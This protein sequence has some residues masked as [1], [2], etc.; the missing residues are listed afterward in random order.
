MSDERKKSVLNLLKPSTSSRN[1]DYLSKNDVNDVEERR[2]TFIPSHHI[3]IETQSNLHNYITSFVSNYFNSKDISSS[4]SRSVL[5]VSNPNNISSDASLNSVVGVNFVSKDNNYNVFIPVDKQSTDLTNTFHTEKDCNVED[6]SI[7]L[8]LLKTIS[9]KKADNDKKYFKHKKSSSAQ[10]KDPF[11]AESIDQTDLIT[12]PEQTITLPIADN[13]PIVPEKKTA[14]IPHQNSSLIP[15]NDSDKPTEQ[16]DSN[17]LF[18]KNV[19]IFS[20]AG[21]NLKSLQN[22]HLANILMEKKSP[23]K[24]ILYENIFIK[25]DH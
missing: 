5:F 4:N 12:S 24:V 10:N 7:A 19:T 9:V 20:N 1:Q 17:N 14:I 16:D 3:P 13:I 22:Q 8:P 25:S 6:A 18:N 23:N 11:N 15:E 2:Y 21:K